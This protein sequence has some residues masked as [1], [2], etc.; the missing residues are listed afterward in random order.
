MVKCFLKFSNTNDPLLFDNIV[1]Y[2]ENDRSISTDV[3]G[4][5]LKYTIPL[6]E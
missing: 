6:L 2:A 3:I 1:L 4:A 5:Y